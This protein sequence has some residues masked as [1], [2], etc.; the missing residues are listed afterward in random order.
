M[1]ETD[2][3]SFI[4][5]TAKEQCELYKDEGCHWHIGMEE[6][7]SVNCWQSVTGPDCN[8]FASDYNCHWV[9]L[10]QLNNEFMCC[11]V[12]IYFNNYILAHIIIIMYYKQ[13]SIVI[14]Y[15]ILCL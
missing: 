15:L 12:C 2:C 10:S 13:M 5:P 9:Q 3:E 7:R 4:G 1:I 6:C 8:I 11:L 14:N